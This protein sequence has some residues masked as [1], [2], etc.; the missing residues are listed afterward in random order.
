M[1]SAEIVVVL[2]TLSLVAIVVGLAG[3]IEGELYTGSSPLEDAV[4]WIRR[5]LS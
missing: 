5:V 3:T 1:T 4:S 2:V